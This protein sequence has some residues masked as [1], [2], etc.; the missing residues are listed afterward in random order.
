[1][2]AIDIRKIDLNLL[3]IFEAVYASRNITQAAL[4]L[5]V[6]QPTLSNALGRLRVQ[7]RDPLFVRLDRG[8][9]PTSFS[10][11]IIGSVRNALTVLR[12]GL[13]PPDEFD[14]T[15][16]QRTFRIAVHGFSA[17]TM[18]PTLLQDIDRNAPGIVVE[19]AV[20]DWQDPAEAL[21]SNKLDLAIDS[22]P[23]VDQQIGFD[24]LFYVRPVGIVRKGHPLVDGRLTTEAFAAIGHAILPPDARKRV[25]VESTLLSEG[26]SRRVVCQVATASELAPL[27]AATDL[28]AIVPE[29][30]AAMAA[31]TFGLQVVELPFSVRS[32]RLMAVWSRARENDSG[33]SWLR[34]QIRDVAAKGDRPVDF[35]ALQRR[36]E[37]SR[38]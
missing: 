12:V 6:S 11:T 10:D 23:Q 22:F 13:Q 34:G 7:L 16:A 26:I 8:V 33:L 4:Q 1:M 36:P 28:M 9:A 30:Y 38:I 20:Q 24:S 19:V 2:A 14:Y 5:G 37:H 32:A 15:S 3:V 21:L 27:V 35:S 25:Q 31:A 18:L 29:G 17:I